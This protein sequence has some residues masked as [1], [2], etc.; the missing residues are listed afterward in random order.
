MPTTS[1]IPPRSSAVGSTKV[2]ALAAAPAK[3]KE[4]GLSDNFM[5]LF[6]TQMR[7]QNPLE[8]GDPTQIFQQLAVMT[9]TE[10]M[11]QMEKSLGSMLAS[12]RLQEGA[13][14]IGRDVKY[15]DEEGVEGE[16]TVKR[17]R[18]SAGSLTY[19]LTDGTEINTAAIKE[20]S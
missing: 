4:A 6:I 16:G 12:N 2:G 15:A 17:L 11:V 3:S 19:I 8:P 5:K 9:Q 18:I 13:A 14:M 10:K 1:P 7:N 20:V